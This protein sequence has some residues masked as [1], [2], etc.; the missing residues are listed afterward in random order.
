MKNDSPSTADISFE[1][2]YKD[3]KTRFDMRMISV[4]E[5]MEI[6]QQ[7]ANIESSDTAKEYEICLSALADFS[8]SAEDGTKLREKFSNMNIRNERIV[9]TAYQQFKYALSPETNFF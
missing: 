3:D 5:E 4:S 9:R 6:N 2:G 8:N 7:F 1:V